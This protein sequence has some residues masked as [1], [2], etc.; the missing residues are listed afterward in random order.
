[1]VRGKI[2]IKRIEDSSSR[3]V[4]FSKRRSGI[5]KKAFELSV[6]CDAEV[7]AIIFSAKGRLYEFSSSSSI[8]ETINRYMMNDINASQTIKK[9]NAAAE[10]TDPET[11]LRKTLERVDDLRG[12]LLGE[13]LDECSIEELEKLENQL[14][15]SISKVRSKK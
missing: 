13:K 14:A 11:E 12:K 9:K 1:M 3:H 6:L 10:Q 5:L 8:D 2:Q 15:T 4:T 7:A